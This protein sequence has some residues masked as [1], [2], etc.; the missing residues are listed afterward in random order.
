MPVDLIAAHVHPMPS[1]ARVS[2]DP[3]SCHP[4]LK[5]NAMTSSPTPPCPAQTLQTKPLAPSDETPRHPIILVRLIHPQSSAV[6]SHLVKDS[7]QK[8]K[9]GKL[10]SPKDMEQQ[11][12]TKVKA[13][14]ATEI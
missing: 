5:N 12:P 10:Q 11:Q 2:L 8:K 14:A 1:Q 7:S 3:R 6:A 4:Q 9:K 13:T